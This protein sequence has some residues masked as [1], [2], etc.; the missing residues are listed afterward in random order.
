MKYWGE[1]K[2]SV[3]QYQMDKDYS[4]YRFHER[5]LPNEVITKEPF[6]FVE[7]NYGAGAMSSKTGERG[8]APALTVPFVTKYGSL[9]L[10][11]A[12]PNNFKIDDVREYEFVQRQRAY[13]Y[14][15]LHIKGSAQF[16]SFSSQVGFGSFIT[17]KPLEDK[18]S[19][20]EPNASSLTLQKAFDKNLAIQ[21]LYQNIEKPKDAALGSPNSE[22]T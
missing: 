3:S 8:G 11:G 20:Q 19:G 14:D 10:C 22:S 1:L 2:D 9:N 15:P 18:D 5:L 12:H 7:S 17:S 13:L 21:S 4:Q 6:F 16:K